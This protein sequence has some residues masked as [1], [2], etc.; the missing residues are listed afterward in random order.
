VSAAS[1]EPPDANIRRRQRTVFCRW[2][3]SFRAVCLAAEF[4]G[5]DLHE[6]GRNIPL[7]L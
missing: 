4:H 3:S 7:S 6:I 5:A 2:A 1:F